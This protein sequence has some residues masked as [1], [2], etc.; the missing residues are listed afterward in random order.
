METDPTTKK[1]ERTLFSM[2][3]V[4]NG[5][6]TTF[7]VYLD[8]LEITGTSTVSV[9]ELEPE[10]SMLTVYPNPSNGVFSLII[11]E[12]VE[13]IEISD[14]TGKIV[15]SMSNI[16]QSQME[17]DLSTQSKGVYIIKAISSTNV[18]TDRIILE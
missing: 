6:G 8:G 18:S 13:N 17:I 14:L 4:S 5:V 1:E 15:K 9:Q 10:N 11:E 12:N 16:T 3:F 2:G 7:G